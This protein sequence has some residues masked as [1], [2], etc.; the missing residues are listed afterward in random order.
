MEEAA[1]EW[2]LIRSAVIPGLGW[3]YPCDIW[4]V[5]CILVELCSVCD[6]CTTMELSAI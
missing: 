3:T 1:R 6:V 2:I 4:S 5:G